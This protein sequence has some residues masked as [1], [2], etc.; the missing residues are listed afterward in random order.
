MLAVST[1]VVTD[2]GSVDFRLLQDGV[3]RLGQRAYRTAFGG[4]KYAGTD[5]MTE[6]VLEQIHQR[7]EAGEETLKFVE[8]W[9]IGSGA[10]FMTDYEYVVD[11]EKHTSTRQATSPG[12]KLT[13]DQLDFLLNVAI[14]GKKQIKAGRGRFSGYMSQ[15][16][17]GKLV[18]LERWRVSIP[19]HGVV[20]YFRSYPPTW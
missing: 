9:D 20:V 2:L 13:R 16:I 10:F 14:E 11:G 7:E 3:T 17:D 18:H 15:Y 1:G 6:R 12:R 8:G 4:N 5:V 19:G